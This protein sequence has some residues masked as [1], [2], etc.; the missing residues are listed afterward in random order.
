MPTTEFSCLA[1]DMVEFAKLALR[2][3]LYFVNGMQV[4][5]PEDIFIADPLGDEQ[6]FEQGNYHFFLISS[7][8]DHERMEVMEIDNIHS[9][10]QFTVAKTYGGPYI[11][12]MAH[13]ES[14]SHIFRGDL[15]LRNKF[16]QKKGGIALPDDRIK[17]DYFILSG[18][19]MNCSKSVAKRPSP[20]ISK[21]VH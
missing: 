11:E 15:E 19:L 8:A 20:S 6:K 10:R 16:H 7:L 17:Q 21:K 9:G 12:L 5:K 14:A 18:F 1:T 13:F 3:R 2:R 4:K